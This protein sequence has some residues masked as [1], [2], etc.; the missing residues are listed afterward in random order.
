M[1]HALTNQI[2]SLYE[3]LREV[4]FGHLAIRLLPFNRECLRR[5]RKTFCFFAERNQR[6]TERECESRQRDWSSN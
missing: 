2:L 5:Q 6:Q 3:W 4:T 1:P